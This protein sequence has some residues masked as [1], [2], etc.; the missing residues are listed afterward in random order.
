MREERLFLKERIRELEAELAK[1]KTTG[2]AGPAGVPICPNCSTE[3]KPVYMRPVPTDFVNILNA[4]HECPKCKH[5]T[6][7]E[8]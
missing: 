7:I 5:N 4:T 1:L 2:I 8:D 6:R 3:S